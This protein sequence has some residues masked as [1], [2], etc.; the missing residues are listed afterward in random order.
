MDMAEHAQRRPAGAG[1]GWRALIADD[2]PGARLQL[3][4]ALRAF[5]PAI[6]ILEAESG[7]EAMELLVREK[8][9]VAF[10]SLQLPDMTGAEALA[11]ARMREA[12]PVA[13]LMSTKVLPRWVDLST[14]LEAYEFLKKP[15]DTEHVVE[16]LR[17]VRR[18]LMPARTLLIEESGPARQVVRRMLA[19][20]R[21]A[22]EIDEID[23]ARHSLKLMRL[24]AYDLVVVDAA[25]SGGN[26]LEVACQAREISPQT[27]VLL[28][29]GGADMA[30]H[31]SAAKQ[32]GIAAL[33]AKPFYPRDVDLALHA[34]FD[35]RRPYLLNAIRKIAPAAAVQPVK[36]AAR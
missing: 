6:R 12:R 29:A 30:R 8:P 14:E 18:M 19:N 1:S 35:L 36:A 20:S 16:L 13:I 32:F 22:L 15:F 5:D 27:R 7:R 31:A 28:T 10:V 34:A 2:A 3:A 11:V 24:T 26:G 25:L 23:D 33:L 4:V 17:A 21:F 9:E